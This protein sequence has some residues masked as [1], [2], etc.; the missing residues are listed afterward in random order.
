[1]KY[2]A[3]LFLIYWMLAGAAHASTRTDTPSQGQYLENTTVVLEEIINA[4]EQGIPSNLNIHRQAIE[5]E[6][7]NEMEVVNKSSLEFWDQYEI[8]PQETVQAASAANTELPPI[9]NA[10]TPTPMP[11]W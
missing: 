3:T 1:M 7:E 10:L 2:I 11:L 6:V 9:Q 8:A 4:P 5:L